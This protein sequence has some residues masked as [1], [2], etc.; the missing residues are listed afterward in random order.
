M[1]KTRSSKTY[2][3]LS[4]YKIQQYK[5]LSTTALAISLRTLRCPSD[6]RNPIQ[7][8]AEPLLTSYDTSRCSI[9]PIFRLCLWDPTNVLSCNWH[10]ASNTGS[11]DIPRFW[12][13][14]RDAMCFGYVTTSQIVYA[15]TQFKP[16]AKGAGIPPKK[17]LVGAAT[18]V[19]L[20]RTWSFCRARCL[21]LEVVSSSCQMQRVEVISPRYS[22]TQ[23]H[24][25]RRSYRYVAKA[26]LG[27]GYDTTT[28]SKGSPE[29]RN[30]AMKPSSN[31]IFE[32][33]AELNA[34]QIQ[35]R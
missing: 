35:P 33:N 15:A 26:G 28:A 29:G 3:A 14:A 1:H 18:R 31:A 5:Q 30:T 12:K 16:V 17:S 24:A 20:L 25:G 19:T 13:E 34:I 9:H 10:E 11:L 32:R 8:A 4:K 23:S 22:S 6:A 21:R 2:V 27:H 7:V